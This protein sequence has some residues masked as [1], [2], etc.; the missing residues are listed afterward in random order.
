MQWLYMGKGEYFGPGFC[1]KVFCGLVRQVRERESLCATIG[2][3]SL[4][5]SWFMLEKVVAKGGVISYLNG[6]G[7]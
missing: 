7:K 1:D 3:C 2:F 5:A 6:C 4:T